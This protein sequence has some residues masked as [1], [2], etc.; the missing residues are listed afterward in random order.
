[1][2]ERTNHLSL[3]LS[4]YT[5]GVRVLAFRTG[6]TEELSNQLSIKHL[7][8]E[9]GYGNDG[10]NRSSAALGGESK[11]KIYFFVRLRRLARTY[12]IISQCFTASLILGNLDTQIVASLKV[13]ILRLFKKQ[14][15]FLPG[16]HHF[17]NFT[18]L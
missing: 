18:R 9:E 3:G 17:L 13:P 15:P 2:E 4:S 16:W 11:G 6:V 7:D 10:N 8:N 14:I 1:M 5:S 12:A